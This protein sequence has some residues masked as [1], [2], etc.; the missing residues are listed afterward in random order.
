[1]AG[2]YIHIPFCKSRCIYCDFYS[3]TCKEYIPKYIDALTR[4]LIFRADYLQTGGRLPDIGT[5]YIGGGTPSLLDT[6]HIHRILD[7]IY[8]VYPVSEQAEITMEANPDDLTEKKIRELRLLPVNR[9]SMGIQTF[10]DEKLQLLHRRHRGKQAADTVRACQDAGFDNISIDLIYGLPRQT[11]ADWE[12]DLERAIELNTQHISAYSLTYEEGTPIWTMREK[13]TVTEAD[14]ELSLDMFKLLTDRL[15]AAHFEHYEISNFAQEGFR[16]RHNS[17]Y[18]EGIPYLGCGPSA[19]S[20]DGHSRQWNCADL[21]TYINRVTSCHCPD[22]FA[23][24]SWIQKEDLTVYESYNDCI[25][26]ALR[27]SKGVNLH[28]LRERFGNRLADYCMENARSHIQRG[29]L[30]IVET[31]KKHTPEGMLKLTRQGIFLSDD[32]M[33]DLLYI[34]DD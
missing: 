9:L 6:A 30:E 24:A 29:T 31:K 7:I 19:H 8:K 12:Y 16:S 10:D 18:W 23:D 13:R 21:H 28:S 5:I 4:E 3:T 33:C 15:S 11:L 27:T 26:T 20:F 32:I 14:E 34:E 22:D 17:S 1:M 2:I 25:V